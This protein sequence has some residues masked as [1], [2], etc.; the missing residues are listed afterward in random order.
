MRRSLWLVVSIGAACATTD[1]NRVS[2]GQST[3]GITEYC[4]EGEIT[5]QCGPE[6]PA[7]NGNF[8]PPGGDGSTPLPPPPSGSGSGTGSGGGGGCGELNCGSG[9]GSG[10]NPPPPPPCQDYPNGPAT[11][12]WPPNH[13]MLSFTLADCANT[14]TCPS[15][16]AAQPTGTITRI[17]VDEAIDLGKGG[18]GHTTQY[19]VQITGPQSFDLRSER[20]GGGDG[21][22]YTVYFSDGTNSGS[23]QFL[24]PHNQGPFA[25]AID[26]GTV[27]TV[28]P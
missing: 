26:S 27:Y 10:S 7:N 4:V 13:K 15:S 5:F 11:M 22:V 17:T 16:G 28:L 14:Y 2:V 21:R 12:L 6:A 9:S 23:C 18:D 3:D 25:G 20:Q 1:S 19:D 24:V 8:Y